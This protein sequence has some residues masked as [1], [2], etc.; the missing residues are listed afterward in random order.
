MQLVGERNRLRTVGGLA[1]DLQFRVAT[2]E[3]VQALTHDAV[4]VGKQHTNGHRSS[5]FRV[6]TAYPSRW[7]PHLPLRVTMGHHDLAYTGS[8]SRHFRTRVYHAPTPMGDV[9]IR[10][11]LVEQEP[12]IGR[13]LCMWLRQASREV[14]VVGEATT[15]AEALALAHELAPD[16]VLLDLAA[17]AVE[18]IAVTVA[19][20]AAAPD[21]RAGTAQPAR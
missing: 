8:K 6:R 19:L 12:L 2:Q 1:Y 15:P 17:P 11:L 13:G 10:L 14:S 3:H 20:R 7:R 5:P 21:V 4:I 18:A 9:M 16:V